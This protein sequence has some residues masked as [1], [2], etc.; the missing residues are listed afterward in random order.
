MVFATGLRFTST[1]GGTGAT[2]VAAAAAA[3]AAA[4][5]GAG[6]W[7]CWEVTAVMYS[8]CC[9]C[10]RVRLLCKSLGYYLIYYFLNNKI[11]H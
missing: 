11:I 3:A 1:G 10:V 7:G 9:E 2:T 4:T 5:A 8:V 6:G